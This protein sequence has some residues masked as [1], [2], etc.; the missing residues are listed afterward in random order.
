MNCLIVEKKESN[1]SILKSFLGKNPELKITGICNTVEQAF[2][3]IVQNDIQLIIA[4]SEI[5]NL[6]TILNATLSIPSIIVSN[7]KHFA[8]RAFDLGVTDYIIH[9]IEEKRFEKA[10]KKVTEKKM[11]SSVIEVENR[12]IFV[13]SEYKIIKIIYD[14]ILYIEALADYIV[15]Q[16]KDDH[17]VIV[18]S[19]MKSVEDKLPSNPFTRVHRSY[20]VNK[21][22]IETIDNQ[23]ILIGAKNIPIGAHY[24]DSFYKKLNFL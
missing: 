11:L 13:R 16:L 8:S 21:D 7:D 24:K 18:H 9:P 3:A 12:Y 6:A 23:S 17:K 22:K 15:F 20:I 14:E 19:T 2:D 4:E 1:N 10:I 5:E